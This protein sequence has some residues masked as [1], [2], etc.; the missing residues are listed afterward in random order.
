MS[1]QAAAASEAIKR[2]NRFR[3]H[4]VWNYNGAVGRISWLVVGDKNKC[5]RRIITTS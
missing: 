4:Q 2:E 3:R 1:F 5:E